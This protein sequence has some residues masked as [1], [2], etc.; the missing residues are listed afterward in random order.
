[1]ALKDLTDLTQHVR[2]GPEG[3]AIAAFFD[4]DGTLIDGYSAAALYGHR[5]RNLE[6]GPAELLHTM[7]LMAGGETLTEEQFGA[8]LERGLAGWSGR[9]VEDVAEL[10]E[11]LFQQEVAGQLFHET[12]RLVKAHQRRGH[13]VVIS[14]SATRM[15]VEPLAR[16]LGV[17]HLLCTELEAE[18]GL[19]TGRVAGRPP[20]GAGKAAAVLAF[21]EEHGVDLSESFAYGNGDED[22]EF[23]SLVGHPH[24]VNPQPALAAHAEAAGWPVLSLRRRP[25]KLDPR[26]TIRTAALYG[27]WIGSCAA[28]MAIGKLLGNGRRGKD[29]ATEAFAVLSGPLGD[30]Q[31]DV[32]G[33][34]HLWSHRPAVFMINHQSALI[35]LVVVARLLRVN[36]TAVAKKEVKDIPVMGQIMQWLDFSFVDR[37]DTAKA[38]AAMEHAKEQLRNGTSV[39]ISPEGT[40]SITPQVGPFKKG[41]FHL[42]QQAGVP[43]VPI[44]IRNAGELMWRNAKTARAGTVEVVVHPPIPTVGWEKPDL[45]AAVE[46]VHRLYVETLAEWPSS[47]AAESAD[48]PSDARS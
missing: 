46:E 28:G 48:S 34:Q 2:S 45:D 13:T 26:P 21:A 8:L 40:R 6:V 38:L 32:I 19:L 15:Q 7:R 11:R 16:E 44:V 47:E 23:L 12:F 20:W 18:D 17:E 27:A 5:M 41:P 29:F 25:G 14:T 22:V 9:P 33:E 42:A 3:P 4:F 1:M 39:V 10:G 24:P 43:I 31:V 30:V 37:S 36:L 35:D